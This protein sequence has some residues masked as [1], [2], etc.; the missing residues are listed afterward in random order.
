MAT[1]PIYEAKN[2]NFQA[3]RA[4]ANAGDYAGTTTQVL[5]T[6][7]ATPGCYVESLTVTIRGTSTKGQI[8]FFLKCTTGPLVTLLFAK[9]IPA[10]VA[11]PGDTEPWTWTINYYVPLPDTTYTLEFNME[12]NDSVDVTGKGKSYV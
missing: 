8:R 6:G 10:W 2:A 12:T 3:H 1:T 5:A 11:T 4:T 7:T 9:N